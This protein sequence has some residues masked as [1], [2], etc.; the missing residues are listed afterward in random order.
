MHPQVSGVSG[1]KEVIISSFFENGY[2]TPLGLE[3]GDYISKNHTCPRDLFI[4]TLVQRGYSAE[5]VQKELDRQCFYPTLRFNHVD[6]TYKGVLLGINLWSDICKRI[7]DQESIVSGQLQVKGSFIKVD[8]YRTDFQFSKLR[9]KVKD[10]GLYKA[11]V[12]RWTGQF[13]KR[14]ALAC[15]D[16]LFEAVPFT[17]PHTR[18][19]RFSVLEAVG[20]IIGRKP[21]KPWAWLVAHPVVHLELTPVARKVLETLFS[22]S[23]GPIDWKGT[24]ISPYEIQ[25]NTDI[26]FEE[27]QESLE[28]LEET[29]IVR[30]VGEDFTPTGLGYLLVRRALRG[31]K[32]LTFAVTRNAE[33]EC[34]LEV[35]T[36]S[37][38]GCEVR[39]VLSQCGGISI[40]EYSTPVVI[41]SCERSQVVNVME[42]VLS[43]VAKHR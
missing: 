28:Y 30:Q 16:R 15:L 19:D 18:G 38:L 34:R 43:K 32:S 9:K 36:P 42:K 25:M 14:E 17:D 27:I 33:T 4:D 29:G 37:Y 40:S 10:L 23:N 6:D 20:D 22:L 39:D 21:G 2:V 3:I 1:D 7:H 11:P 24:H 12:M 41:S 35:S 8:I 31:D 13:T 26:S 5:D